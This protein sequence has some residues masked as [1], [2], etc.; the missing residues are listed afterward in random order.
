MEEFLD[1]GDERKMTNLMK[2]L[3]ENGED[4]FK[5]IDELDDYHTD[6]MLD[7]L[8]RYEPELYNKYI[9]NV[10]ELIDGTQKEKAMKAYQDEQAV[11]NIIKKPEIR[12]TDSI[13][14]EYFKN[15]NEA[16]ELE[17]IF[18]DNKNALN[19]TEI[20]HKKS[21]FTSHINEY[22]QRIE[23]G[24]I[25]LKAVDKLT[26]RL[27]NANI[28]KSEKIKFINNNLFNGNKVIS[29]SASMKSVN[30]FLESLEDVHKVIQNKLDFNAGVVDN[31]DLNNL[32]KNTQNFLK[33]L[34]DTGIEGMPNEVAKSIVNRSMPL[35]DEQFNTKMSYLAHKFGYESIDELRNEV[36][37]LKARRKELDN[38]RKTKDIIEEQTSLSAR[39]KELNNT[40]DAR[41]VEWNKIKGMNEGQLQKYLIDNDETEFLASIKNP[42]FNNDFLRSDP[43]KI[44]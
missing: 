35:I 42:K 15:S 38:Y 40:I 16:Y 24:D 5:Y 21:A 44:V 41:D 31:F 32:S 43:P 4:V 12:N 13:D 9:N 7:Y 19:M 39:I 6:R 28:P 23:N 11:K 27:K 2:M 20:R 8:E 14:K 18:K 36:K 30:S 29:E 22:V 10:D 26:K 37:A 1:Y 3:D 17:K 25:Q 33:N 34:K